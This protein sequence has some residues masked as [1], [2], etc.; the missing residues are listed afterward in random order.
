MTYFTY[1]LTHTP[2]FQTCVVAAA[3]TA[4]PLRTSSFTDE[5]LSALRNRPTSSSSLTSTNRTQGSAVSTA[6]KDAKK[7]GGAPGGSCG[8]ASVKHIIRDRY[9]DVFATNLPSK[10]VFGAEDS[11]YTI[12]SVGTKRQDGSHKLAICLYYK[13]ISVATFMLFNTG[14]KV[15]HL[16]FNIPQYVPKNKYQE[17]TKRRDGKDAKMDESGIP[18]ISWDGYGI[19]L[20]SDTSLD[21]W[22]RIHSEEGGPAFRQALTDIFCI[23]MRSYRPPRGKTLLVSGMLSYPK[24]GKLVTCNRVYSLHSPDDLA[25]LE[26]VEFNNYHLALLDKA[27]C[28]EGHIPYM[29]EVS[30]GTMAKGDPEQIRLEREQ[31]LHRLHTHVKRHRSCVPGLRMTAREAEVAIFH[32]AQIVMNNAITC[33]GNAEKEVRF[34]VTTKDQ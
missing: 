5:F 17:Q 13:I 24:N 1:V 29:P 28:P 21:E 10:V 11:T 34:W 7:K 8:K 9:K 12:K 30:Y 31:Y 32:M 25:L 14:M 18:R 27:S 26:S 15:Y 16:V 19:Y 2:F 4:V 33:R 23:L 22:P 20:H 6:P 3:T